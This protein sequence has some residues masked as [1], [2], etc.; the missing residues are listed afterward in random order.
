M[1]GDVTD[2][3]PSWLKAKADD[4]YRGGDLLSAINAY[5]AAL[6]SDESFVPVISNRSNCYL[7]LGRYEDCINDC[8]EALLLLDTESGDIISVEEDELKIDLKPSP[9]KEQKRKEKV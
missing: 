9:K 3:D 6:D 4:F 2:E 8:S 7:R 5:T 1:G